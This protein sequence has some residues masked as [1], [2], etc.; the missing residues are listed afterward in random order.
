MGK[1]GTIIGIIVVV[2]AIAIMIVA[3][4]GNNTKYYYEVEQ[5]YAQIDTLGNKN[6][7]VHGDLLEMTEEGKTIT[8]TI[9]D[10]NDASKTITATYTG[11]VPAQMRNQQDDM[12]VTAEGKYD[13]D[14]KIFT[15]KELIMECASK[16]EPAT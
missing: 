13:F 9:A 11:P 16:Y 14:K 2:A 8:I 1:R 6:V 15:A 7:K 10:I 12:K 4:A 5:Y 3:F